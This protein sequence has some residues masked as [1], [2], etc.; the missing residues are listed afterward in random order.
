MESKDYRIGNLLQD[1]YR[2]LLRVIELSRENQYFEVID[3]SK[4]PL[5]TDWKAEPIILTVQ[6]LKELFAD[7]GE[8]NNCE[9][10]IQK[11]LFEIRGNRL[12]YTGGEG[13]KLSRNIEYVHDLQNLY[14]AITGKD[15]VLNM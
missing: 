2:N 1:Q 5:P 15:L 12:Y 7:V 10:V 9:I 4:F 11:E 13:V 3:R 14:Y 8:L 6:K